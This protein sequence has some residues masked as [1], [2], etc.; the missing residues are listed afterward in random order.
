MVLDRAMLEDAAAVVV[1]CPPP[2]PMGMLVEEVE[3]K[4]PSGANVNCLKVLILLPPRGCLATLVGRIRTL[5]AEGG[6]WS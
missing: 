5:A 2:P 4:V 6:T 3:G 1:G